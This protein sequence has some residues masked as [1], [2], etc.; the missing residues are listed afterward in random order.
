M[1]YVMEYV[2]A[3]RMEYVMNEKVEYVIR[4]VEY[5]INLKF[6]KSGVRNGVRNDCREPKLMVDGRNPSKL[7]YSI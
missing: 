5:V 4:G 1:E 3:L 7:S 6:L 2:M